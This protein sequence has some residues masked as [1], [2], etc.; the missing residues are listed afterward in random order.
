[1]AILDISSATSDIG[2]GHARLQRGQAGFE[3][4]RE[5]QGGFLSDPEPQTKD[6]HIRCPGRLF[7]EAIKE[8]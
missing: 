3:P 6:P 8:Y 1:M 5:R 7:S 2:F 4:R